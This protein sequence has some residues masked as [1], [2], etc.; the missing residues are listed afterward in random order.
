[1]TPP[2]AHGA[3]LARADDPRA[4]R[5]PASVF[6]ARAWFAPDAGWKNL[7]D[8]L[9]DRA[10]TSPHDT[11]FA[12]LQQGPAPRV[13]SYVEL[14]SAARTCAADLQRTLSVGDNAVLA[15]PA[16]LD[17][18][19]AFFGCLYAG[20][21][22][23]PVQM[24][25]LPE[26][27]RRIE[28]IAVA[29]EARAIL[30]PSASLERLR[31]ASTG[32]AAATGAI[33]WLSPPT[34]PDTETPAL[35]PTLRSAPHDPCFLQFS[36]G[37]TGAPRG[38]VVTHENILNNLQMLNLAFRI[39]ARDLAVSWLPHHHDMGLIAGI[40]HAVYSGIPAILMAPL[41]FLLRPD[42]WLKTISDYRATLS[43]GPNF[44]YEHCVKSLDVKA[45][46]SV[47]LRSWEVAISGS[48]PIR[49]E[50]LAA[51][52]EAFAPAGFSPKAFYPSYG[53]AEATLMVSGASRGGGARV[54]E[55][56]AA[57]LAQGRIAKPAAGAATR[58]LVGCGPPKAE[59]AIVRPGTVDRARPGEIGEILVSGLSVSPGYY[60]P[61]GGVCTSQMV[62]GPG[63]GSFLR[64]GDLGVEFKGE[65]CIVGRL[66]DLVVVRGRNVHPADVEGAVQGAE[67][68]FR[69]GGGA[70]FGIDFGDGEKLVLVQEVEVAGEASPERLAA[71]F[72]A[73]RQ[74]VMRAE[75]LEI[76][77]IVL[78]APGQIPKTT[79]GKVRR[80][81]CRT[82][83]L[84]NGLRELARWPAASDEGPAATPIRAACSQAADAHE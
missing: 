39:D 42:L 71:H 3:D 38:V 64:T 41:A 49:A 56:D 33:L 37:S 78:V 35:A 25:L 13:M 46:R 74:A 75:G 43:A 6:H 17:F 7:T 61:G 62:T 60:G 18:I 9:R 67:P 72:A 48:E 30:A 23:A 73:A 77:R 10:T 2:S 52:G 5:A 57:D 68:A 80:Q 4:H 45:R 31:A 16:G 36:S 66:K 34:A 65:L 81:E 54:F 14:D 19:V 28:A 32:L 55:V 8:C 40:L 24:S 58:T 82:R 29:S 15:Y 83:F 59:V 22:P 53:L 70:A 27:V 51:F 26:G 69:Q 63:G 1:M 44:A 21:R 12:F 11:A 20:V 47:D 79:S 84:E 76:D 50:T